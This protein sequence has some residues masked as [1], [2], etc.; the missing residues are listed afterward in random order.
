[1]S[2]AVVTAILA[3][4]LTLLAGALLQRDSASRARKELLELAELREKVATEQ[5]KI[6]DVLIESRLRLAYRRASRP[7]SVPRLV[8]AA[9]LLMISSYAL[10]PVVSY[11]SERAS[12][13]AQQ[14]ARAQSLQQFDVAKRFADDQALG[15]R[16]VTAM[17]Y[18]GIAAAVAGMCCAIAA[19]VSLLVWVNREEP[20]TWARLLRLLGI[21][22][23]TESGT[24]GDG[25]NPEAIRAKPSHA[26]STER[27]RLADIAARR[28]MRR[29]ALR[30]PNLL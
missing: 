30:N 26:D 1:V 12:R 25:D 24:H 29:L 14:V 9:A 6:V 28:R 21:R 17:N 4:L 15:E 22:R 3:P 11:Y 2:T 7:K 10:F 13:D 23:T 5:G 27:E 18:A 19:G 16:L 8:T 20:H